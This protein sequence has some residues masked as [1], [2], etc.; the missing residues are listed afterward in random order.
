MAIGETPVM[1][2]ILYSKCRTYLDETCCLHEKKSKLDRN[3]LQVARNSAASLGRAGTLRVW[4][5]CPGCRKIAAA[6]IVETLINM[7]D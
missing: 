3:R 5:H 2:F 6:R 4:W 1:V 7:M